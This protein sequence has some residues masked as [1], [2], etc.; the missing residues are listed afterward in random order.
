M[1]MLTMPKENPVLVNFQVPPKVLKKFDD[2]L[3]GRS[4][5]A[6]LVRLMENV[7]N[8]TISVNDLF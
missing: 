4:R 3:K 6:V 7:N 5:S 8:G 1:V 2:G